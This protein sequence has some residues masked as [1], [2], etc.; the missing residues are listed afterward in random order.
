MERFASYIK[1]LSNLWTQQFFDV[2]TSQLTWLVLNYKSHYAFQSL[3][4]SRVE[5]KIWMLA[6][7]LNQPKFLLNSFLQSF[8]HGE[9]LAY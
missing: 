6:T 3:W 8:A 7:E 9:E 4:E 2:I 5:K 1:L